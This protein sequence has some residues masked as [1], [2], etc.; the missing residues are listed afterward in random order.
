LKKEL[1]SRGRTISQQAAQL[2]R[3]RI[4]SNNVNVQTKCT[5]KGVQK[6]MTSVATFPEFSPTQFSLEE[7]EKLLGGNE[8]VEGED[9]ELTAEEAELLLAKDL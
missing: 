4:S 6:A 3:Y 8:L 2:D 7:A 5:C 1:I 9:S